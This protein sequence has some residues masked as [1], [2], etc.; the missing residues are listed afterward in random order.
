[1]K[2]EPSDEEVEQ[3][4][5]QYPEGAPLEVIAEVC[6][7]TR[8]R[9]YQLLIGI[10]VKALRIYLARGYSPADIRERTTVWDRLEQG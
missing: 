7:L 3:V 1:L 10:Q 9:I 2:S 6:H 5:A 4:I 8:P